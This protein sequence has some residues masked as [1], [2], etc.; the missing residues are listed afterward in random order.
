MFFMFVK[1]GE[2]RP[3]FPE[4]NPLEKALEAFSAIDPSMPVSMAAT[5][6][7][8]ARCSPELATGETNLRAIAASS[9]L[10]YSTFLRHV[11]ALAD[12]AGP[13]VKGLKL[14]EKGFNAADRRAR[15]VRLTQDG[16]RFLDDLGRIFTGRQSSEEIPEFLEIPE[17]RKFPENKD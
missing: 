4:L 7:R 9:G 17:T 15:A 13:K 10:A 5:L 11:D 1:P 12:G 16:M 14:V 6:L 2:V 8:V 3:T